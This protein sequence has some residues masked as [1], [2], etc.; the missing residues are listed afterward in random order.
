MLYDL[1]YACV[2]PAHAILRIPSALTCFTAVLADK[3]M[4]VPFCF[5]VLFFLC[6]RFLCF[7]V[8]LFAAAFGRWEDA[9]SQIVSAK[10]AFKASGSPWRWRECT[11][12]Q[13]LLLH[14]QSKLPESTSYLDKVRII[15]RAVRVIS[16]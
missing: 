14:F 5:S 11:F 1:A 8:S 9:L 13:A 12:H 16:H 10:M 6:A 3:A 15:L 2:Q 4:L 7:S